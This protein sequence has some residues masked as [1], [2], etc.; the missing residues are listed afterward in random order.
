M[1]RTK[2]FT[3]PYTVW[4]ALFVVAPIIMIVVYAFSGADGGFTLSNFSTMGDYTV[5][6]I[7]SF[8][9]A[10]IATECSGAETEAPG[11][12]QHGGAFTRLRRA[13]G[14]HPDR[15]VALAHGD[16]SLVTLQRKRNE[17]NLAPRARIERATPRFV[18]KCSDPLS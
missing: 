2:V 5:V 16:Y 9:L 14:D 18:G 3:I 4:M 8:R 12:C 17:K 13:H 1:K 11:K 10:L 6:F 7:R 15:G